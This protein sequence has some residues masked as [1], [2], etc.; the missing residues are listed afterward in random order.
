MNAQKVCEEIINF[1]LNEGFRIE[2]SKSDVEKAI[3]YIR[4]I[5]ERTIQK[6]LKALVIFGYLKPRT[7]FIY[8][9]NPIKVPRVMKMLKEKP[10]TKIL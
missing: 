6:W 8:Q 1:L 9:I 10:Q 4:G 2:V 7:P 5:D 3:M